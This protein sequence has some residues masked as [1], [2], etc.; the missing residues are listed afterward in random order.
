M[1][2]VGERVPP[3]LDASTGEV[4]GRELELGVECGTL[5]RG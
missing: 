2:L 1:A 4:G 3:L 5:A